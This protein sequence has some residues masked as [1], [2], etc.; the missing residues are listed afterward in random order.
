MVKLRVNKEETLPINNPEGGPWHLSIP[1]GG[2]GVQINL[3]KSL[4][5]PTAPLQAGRSSLWGSLESLHHCAGGLP[6]AEG[7]IATHFVCKP[8]HLFSPS[9]RYRIDSARLMRRASQPPRGARS[10]PEAL[11]CGPRDVTAGQSERGE[12]RRQANQSGPGAGGGLPRAQVCERSPAAPHITSRY[13][14][15]FVALAVFCLLAGKMGLA[16]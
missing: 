16:A 10:W 13:G 12:S 5:T 11:A 2:G 7:L 3:R 9:P 6:R 8:C 15:V 14:G 1:R 4:P